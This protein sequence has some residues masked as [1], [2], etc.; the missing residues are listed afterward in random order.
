M[1]PYVLVAHVSQSLDDNSLKEHPRIS[2]LLQLINEHVVPQAMVLKVRQHCLDGLLEPKLPGPIPRVSHSVVGLWICI[3]SKF[4]G[5]ADAPD[6]GPC[7]AYRQRQIWLFCEP[8]LRTTLS[9]ARVNGPEHPRSPSLSPGAA[10]GNLGLPGTWLGSHRPRGLHLEA[11]Y[12]LSLQMFC[13]SLPV[14][15]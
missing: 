14:H 4:S 11:E 3:S 9:E 10:S 7:F 12:L 15:K 8:E 5:N 6:A 2:I 1:V 13:H